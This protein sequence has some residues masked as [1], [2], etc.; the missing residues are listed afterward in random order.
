MLCLLYTSSPLKKR[1]SDVK[2]NQFITL[3]A[4]SA[5]TCLI[6]YILLFDSKVFL[7]LRQ[8]V[9]DQVLRMITE[10]KESD[11]NPLQMSL[12]TIVSY[13]HATFSLSAPSQ[14][15]TQKSAN[16]QITVTFAT[17]EGNVSLTPQ[18]HWN[19]K[20]A[21]YSEHRCSDFLRV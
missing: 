21:S 12:I 1:I 2:T 17:I 11:S 20:A 3:S 16:Q 9:V 18:H 4:L 8:V 13:F 19:F 14:S 7:H 5:L 10:N 15:G 6:L